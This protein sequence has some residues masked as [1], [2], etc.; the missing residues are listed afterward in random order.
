MSTE[1]LLGKLAQADYYDYDTLEVFLESGQPLTQ[2]AL[3][4]LISLNL[5]TVEAALH[6]MKV[7]PS[8]TLAK[9]LGRKKAARAK[10]TLQEGSGVIRINGMLRGQYFKELRSTR[11]A[12]LRRLLDVPEVAEWLS[13][14]DAYIQVR[15]SSPEYS[16][17]LKAVA[18]ALANALGQFDHKLGRKLEKLGYG[19]A[20]V[21]D[22]FED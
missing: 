11:K 14:M 3:D 8:P 19:G 15:G 16:G 1:N 18:H 21:Q 10:V 7:A 17:Q 20:K 12:F 2:A 4:H 13:Q 22:N 5:M 9:G 6:G